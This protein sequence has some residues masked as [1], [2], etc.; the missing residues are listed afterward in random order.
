MSASFNCEHCGEI[1]GEFKVHFDMNYIC[2]A[3]RNVLMEIQ[4]LI[5]DGEKK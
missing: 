2:E 1:S 5:N 3:C 4:L